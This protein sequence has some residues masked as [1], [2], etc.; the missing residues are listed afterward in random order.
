MYGFIIIIHPDSLWY[1]SLSNHA[2]NVCFIL[3]YFLPDTVATALLQSEDT[4]S[5]QNKPPLPTETTT[6]IA[7][8]DYLA[9]CAFAVCNSFHGNGK[10]IRISYFYGIVYIILLCSHYI[11]L[12]CPFMKRRLSI[13]IFDDTGGFGCRMSWLKKNDASR[14]WTQKTLPDIKN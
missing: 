7:D 9:S 6:K 13:A 8:E 4:K 10:S 1:S 2:Q 14:R 5:Y 3:F 12:Q 11:P